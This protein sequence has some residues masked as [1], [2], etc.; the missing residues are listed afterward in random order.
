MPAPSER[1]NASSN[2][3]PHH[4]SPTHQ[5]EPVEIM[6]LEEFREYKGAGPVELDLT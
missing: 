5:V 1:S 3:D 6:S 2:H 4:P